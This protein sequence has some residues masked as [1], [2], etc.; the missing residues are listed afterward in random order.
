MADAARWKL[1]AAGHRD[2][3]QFAGAVVSNGKA[4][5]DPQAFQSSLPSTTVPLTQSLSPLKLR[6]PFL[7]FGHR[8]VAERRS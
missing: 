5:R 3:G 2:D 4:Q 8:H 6:R 1:S 7:Q